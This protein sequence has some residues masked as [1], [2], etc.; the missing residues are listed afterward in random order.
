MPSGHVLGMLPVSCGFDTHAVSS[1]FFDFD[2]KC[3]LTGDP[4]VKSWQ[5]LMRDEINAVGN[6]IANASTQSEHLR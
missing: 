5:F 4:C 2:Q 6:G 3:G 1:S